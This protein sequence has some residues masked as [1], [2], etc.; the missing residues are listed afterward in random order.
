[1]K[2]FSTPTSKAISKVW[3]SPETRILS[4]QFKPKAAVYLYAGVPKPAYDGFAKSSSK[5]KYFAKFIRPHYPSQVD[6][7]SPNFTR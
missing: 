7:L 3:Y 2:S 1:M 6:V 5:G 4:V